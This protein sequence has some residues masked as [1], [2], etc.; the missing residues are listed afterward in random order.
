MDTN[1]PHDLVPIVVISHSRQSKEV[2]VWTNNAVDF[3]KE[4]LPELADMLVTAL[5]DRLRI[6]IDEAWMLVDIYRAGGKQ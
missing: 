2:F 6:S 4:T 3:Q 5:A 1:V